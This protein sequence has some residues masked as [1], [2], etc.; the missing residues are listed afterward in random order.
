MGVWVWHM[1]GLRI[2][3]ARLAAMEIGPLRAPPALHKQPP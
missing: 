2:A 3:G 1:P